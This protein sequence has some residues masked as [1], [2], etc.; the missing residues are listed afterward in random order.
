MRSLFGYLENF[1]SREFCSLVSY[2]FPKRNSVDL[3]RITSR[4]TERE[5]KS[6][7]NLSRAQKTFVPP[8][9]LTLTPV[10]RTRQG[11]AE[12]E[13]FI[14]RRKFSRIWGGGRYISFR[15]NRSYEPQESI[16]PVI[17]HRVYLPPRWGFDH[18]SN[19]HSTLISCLFV[20][21]WGNL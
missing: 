2:K 1:R 15:S 19:A 8:H 12:R 7:V 5:K 16:G 21:Q 14:F 11:K 13:R 18:L 20:Y 9:P 17:L 3:L 4:R 6:F 10:P